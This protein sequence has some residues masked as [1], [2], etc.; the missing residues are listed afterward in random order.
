VLENEVFEIVELEYEK[1]EH[2][3]AP[4]KDRKVA[5]DICCRTSSGERFIVEMQKFFQTH[6][7]KRPL[8]YTTFA[9]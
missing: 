7:I 8:Y 5:F 9:I 4:E 3:G 1:N 6:Y 2:L